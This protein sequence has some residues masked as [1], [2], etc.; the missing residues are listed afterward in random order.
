[1]QAFEDG[2][3]ENVESEAEV[4]KARIKKVQKDKNLDDADVQKDLQ[5]YADL[6]GM[7]LDEVK[8]ALKNDTLSADTIANTLATSKV[9]KKVKTAMEGSVKVLSEKTAGKSKR[10]IA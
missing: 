10:E 9:D 2:Y 5:E 6:Q 8:A 3:T 7:T 4:I 1:M